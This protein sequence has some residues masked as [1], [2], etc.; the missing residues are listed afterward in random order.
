MEIDID[1][2]VWRPV[3]WQTDTFPKML[4]CSVHMIPH[5]VIPAHTILCISDISFIYLFFFI[6]L[7]HCICHFLIFPSADHGELLQPAKTWEFFFRWTLQPSNLM[8]QTVSR[9]RYAHM[10]FIRRYIAAI[11]AK[12]TAAWKIGI[13]I[14][15]Q[16]IGRAGIWNRQITGEMCR[17]F[18]SQDSTLKD[19]TLRS[20]FYRIGSRKC[21][22]NHEQNV[23]CEGPLSTGLILLNSIPP[24]SVSL[25]L[26][27][28]GLQYPPHH[29]FVCL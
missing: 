1:L 17:H 12:Y 21:N 19:V 18:L 15:I 23:A 13:W 16:H 29:I 5:S 25:S 26:W 9:S 28:Y 3:W 14:K 24:V 11:Q 6:F 27:A 22:Q 20:Y 7:G 2:P 4:K 10:S 8:S